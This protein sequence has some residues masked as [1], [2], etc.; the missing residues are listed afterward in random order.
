MCET[1][2][3]DMGVRSADTL[4]RCVA[5]GGSRYALAPDRMPR[6][7]RSDQIVMM[8][9]NANESGRDGIRSQMEE[10]LAIA[11]QSACCNFADGSFIDP[12]VRAILP[13]LQV[14][15]TRAAAAQVLGFE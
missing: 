11:V 2:F 13:S 3:R 7:M 14:S 9:A 4:L 15:A 10:M 6:P 8:I 12:D 1:C 5:E